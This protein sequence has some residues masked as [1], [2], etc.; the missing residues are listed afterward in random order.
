M[1]VKDKLEVNQDEMKEEGKHEITKSNG[2][3]ELD[4]IN[5]HDFDFDMDVSKEASAI[6]SDPDQELTEDEKKYDPFPSD[7]SNLKAPRDHIQKCVKS[8]GKRGLMCPKCG[9]Q[10]DAQLK[11][12]TDI[13]D[14]IGKICKN[15]HE[16]QLLDKAFD[17]LLHEIH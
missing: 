7:M 3:V 9:K 6:G 15:E 11:R 12:H 17:T 8:Q 1:F 16:H 10:F 13:C 14:P 4:T 5:E 2:N